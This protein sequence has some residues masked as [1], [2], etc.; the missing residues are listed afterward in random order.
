MEQYNVLVV[1]DD[2]EITEAIEIYLSNEKYNVFKAR[3][4]SSLLERR[5]VRFLSALDIE[6]K[7]GVLI[8]IF[9]NIV[10]V[11]ISLDY[12]LDKIVFICYGIIP[13]YLLLLDVVRMTYIIQWKVQGFILK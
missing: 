10:D 3:D 12:F 9:C 4:L 7:L 8:V 6:V 13:M 5:V 11:I 2:K 1:D